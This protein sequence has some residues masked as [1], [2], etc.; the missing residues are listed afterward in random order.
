MMDRRKLLKSLAA[1]VPLKV[2]VGAEKI[3]GAATRLTRGKKYVVAVTRPM[4]VQRWEQFVYGVVH[5]LPADHPLKDA[6]FI[7]T[8]GRDV[9]LY[10]L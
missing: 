6:V 3:E 4:S 10:E 7:N 5:S 1:I 8:D 2:L 9:K